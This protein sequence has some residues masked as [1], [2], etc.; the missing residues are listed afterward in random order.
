MKLFVLFAVFVASAAGSK[1]T[2]SQTPQLQMKVEEYLEKNPKATLKSAISQ[3]NR[4]IETE[5]IYADVLFKSSKDWSLSD[6]YTLVAPKKPNPCDQRI[7]KV[8]VRKLGVTH[9]TLSA[10]NKGKQ[11]VVPSWVQP[12]RLDV[13]TRSSTAVVHSFIVPFGMDPMG[14]DE[15]AEHIY[16]RFSLKNAN[17]ATKAWFQNVF[18]D[19][20][21][22]L[23]DTPFL[24]LSVNRTGALRFL[25]DKEVYDEQEAERF[26]LD[27][28]TRENV[29]TLVYQPYD[30]VV[31]FESFC[32][33]EIR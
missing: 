22:V 6:N 33:A 18:E 24:V 1:K 11:V 12:L 15:K 7:G 23:E 32:E 3:A 25:D 20:P 2:D 10:R 29:R 4:L 21:D 13:L 16:Y 31:R 5:G 17:R 27:D 28:E 19:T 9:F 26:E 14:V 30:W 8:A